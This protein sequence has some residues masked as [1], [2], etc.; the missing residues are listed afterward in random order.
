MK[1]ATIKIEGM[2]CEHCKM[3][4]T[5]ALSSLTGIAEVSVSLEPGTARISYDPEKIGME[6]VKKV[7]EETG[8]SVI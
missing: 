5:K 7:V 4:V 2:M 1:E 3:A 6:D 8:Y